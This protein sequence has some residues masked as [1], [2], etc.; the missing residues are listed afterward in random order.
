MIRW[1]SAQS[2][3]TG[4]GEKWLDSG[5]ILK[6]KSTGISWQFGY[7][8]KKKRGDMD[9]SEE[10]GLIN[11][12]ATTVINWDKNL[13]GSLFGHVTFEMSTIHTNRYVSSVLKA[14]PHITS[15]INFLM[16]KN[17]IIGRKDFG[18]FF[19]FLFLF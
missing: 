16:G 6:V 15:H 9:V 10:S 7:G 12:M 18:K 1:D 3:S 8:G 17:K 11:F 4:D 19:K 2:S 13:A 14:P 5:C